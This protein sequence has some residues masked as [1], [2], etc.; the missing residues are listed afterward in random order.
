MLPCIGREH[1]QLPVTD[2]C[3]SRD[4]DKITCAS[5]CR[6]RWSILLTFKNLNALGATPRNLQPLILFAPY[7]FETGL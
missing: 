6:S 4:D 5:E 7:K 3:R 2:G 1:Y